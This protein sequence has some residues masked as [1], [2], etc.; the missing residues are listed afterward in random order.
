MF[1]QEW[2]KNGHVDGINGH[3]VS[4]TVSIKD[5]EWE[6]VGNWMWENRFNYNGI[7]VLP[8]S[9]HTYKQAPFED[10][11]EDL[12]NEMY[13]ELTNIDLS[14]IIEEQDMTDLQG[15]VACAGGVCE[16]DFVL[17]KVEN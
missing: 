5:N 15:E 7:S 3:N 9:D 10:C 13:R 2:I 16:V 11:E 12:Y 8:Y 14:K 6:M 1:S 4:A 17:P